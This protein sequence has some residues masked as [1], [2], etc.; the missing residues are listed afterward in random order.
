MVGTHTYE[1]VVE[2]TGNQGT[3]T[4]S[5]RAYGRQHEIRAEGNDTSIAGSADPSFRGDPER[6]NPEELLVASLSQCHMLWYLHLASVAGVVVTEYV[7]TPIGTM[8]LERDGAGQFADVTLRPV[9]T[10]A[11]ASMVDKAQA[12]HEDA[13]AKCFI[14]RSVNF[15]VHHAPEIRVAP[16]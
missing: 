7:D 5:Y 13:N 1:L 8:E 10:V 9:V 4:S 12:V 11:D 6:W 3:G 16:G 15:P 14:A 2:W